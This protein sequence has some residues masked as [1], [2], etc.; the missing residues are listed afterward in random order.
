MEH[1]KYRLDFG[2]F[3]KIR[4]IKKRGEKVMK[5]KWWTRFDRGIEVLLAVS[6]FMT[7]TAV[8][9]AHSIRSV[10]FKAPYTIKASRTPCSA[11][12]ADGRYAAYWR[13]SSEPK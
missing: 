9:A 6:L 1:I 2:R 13:E 12:G 11:T 10:R 5:K 3:Y 8:P 7:Q 4:V